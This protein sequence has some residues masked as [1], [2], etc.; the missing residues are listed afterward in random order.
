MKVWIVEDEPAAAR[1]LNKLLLA[2]GLD[3]QILAQLDSIASV[4]QH[5]ESHTL[6]DLI[7]LD[8]HLADGPCFEIF[9]HAD[10]RKPIIF[11]TAYD[12]Y[13][14]EAFKVNAIDYLLKPIKP[15]FLQR[16]LEKFQLYHPGTA[17]DYHA[18]I[19]AMQREQQSYRFLVRIGQRIRLVDVQDAAYFFTENKVTFV[20]TWD[21]TRLPLDV[22]MEKLEEILNERFFFRVN[23]QYIIHFRA[24]R[25]MY[26][27]SKSRV[28]LDLMPSFSNEDIIVSTER[29]PHF[30]RW[31]VGNNSLS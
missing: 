8:I 1:R 27:Y 9:R 2:L 6:P 11:T 15:E 10:I 23:R 13:A 3:I 30:K 16:A 14:I 4:L 5:M 12:Q 18:L 22:T 28:K 7:F 31:L 21:G 20:V 24:I 29:S 17:I 19:R 25:E 26:A